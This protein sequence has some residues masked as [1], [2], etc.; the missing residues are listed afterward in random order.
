LNTTIIRNIIREE[1]GV[2]KCPHC[3]GTGI[4]NV[5]SRSQ[6]ES[7]YNFVHST[8]TMP[9]PHCLGAGLWS[10]YCS[11]SPYMDKEER[12]VVQLPSESI[13]PGLVYLVS[14]KGHSG[15]QNRNLI[16]GDVWIHVNHVVTTDFYIQGTDMGDIHLPVEI[17]AVQ[18]LY[19]FVFSI[20]VPF[21]NQLK[22]AI[23]MA[24]SNSNKPIQKSKSKLK[25]AKTD[26]PVPVSPAQGHDQDYI[27]D[28]NSSGNGSKER[29]LLID[30]T[31]KTTLPGM[32]I[33]MT[34][35]GL[36]G[37]TSGDLV[38]TFSL[39]SEVMEPAAIPEWDEWLSLKEESSKSK[40]ETDIEMSPQKAA[41]KLILQ[42]EAED[43]ANK[44]EDKY[45]DEGDAVE[46]VDT[47]ANIDNEEK[48]NGATEISELDVGR[49]GID[50]TATDT[51]TDTDRVP[52]KK[53]KDKDKD[54]DEVEKTDKPKLVPSP[55][56]LEHMQAL[57]NLRRDTFARKVLNLLKLRQEKKKL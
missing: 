37:K 23:A 43:E 7:N 31:G 45:K 15:Y 34:S 25:A 55:V 6:P 52:D 35:M 57:S 48:K 21:I 9:C 3:N 39:G 8:I 19:G 18:A 47:A 12:L 24:N 36:P 11:D 40:I 56:I 13:R 10:R 54:K 41:E 38:I 4:F 16:T 49:E 5:E 42:Q 2:E 26:T 32:E 46:E 51:E 33:R 20:E 53:E 14:N 1:C 22:E 27:D 44:D 30:R 50:S 17:S 28:S 29:T